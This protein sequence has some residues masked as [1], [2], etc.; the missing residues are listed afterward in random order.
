M[1]SIIYLKS[2]KAL[3]IMLSLTMYVKMG[4][5]VPKNRHYMHFRKQFGGPDNGKEKG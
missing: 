2:C 3:E 5:S 4:I 1:Q